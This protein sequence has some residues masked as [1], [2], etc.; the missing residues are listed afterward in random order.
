MTDVGAFT[1]R[2]SLCGTFAQ[3]GSGQTVGLWTEV[4]SGVTGLAVT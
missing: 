3:T 2:V 1:A 4:S